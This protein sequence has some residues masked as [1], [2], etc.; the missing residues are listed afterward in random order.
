MPHE[1]ETEL[2]VVRQPE[3]FPQEEDIPVEMV[4]PSLT[5]SQ[6][7]GTMAQEPQR[8][9]QRHRRPKIF[10]Y[11]Q[12]GSPACYNRPGSSGE[13]LARQFAALIG[14]LLA[15]VEALASRPACLV[16]RGMPCGTVGGQD[17][18]A[19]VGF[20]CGVGGVLGP[21]PTVVAFL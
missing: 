20:G 6:H 13:V 14:M 21:W 2:D 7:S 19:P 18:G 9:R 4:A 8:L 1:S 15:L 11:D 16:E 10:T 17:A 12:L 3:H 5:P